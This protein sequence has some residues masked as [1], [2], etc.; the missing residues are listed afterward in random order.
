LNQCLKLRK[1][2]TDAVQLEFL[3]MRIQL[4]QVDEVAPALLA[5]VEN[6]HPETPLILETLA[7]AYMHNLRYG[8][9][10]GCLNLWL[11]EAPETA[12]AY[13]WRGW[14]R[15]RLNHAEGA[16]QDYQ[17]GL[18]LDPD[19]FPAR[20][21]VAEILL[22][23][24]NP[25]EALP[26]LERLLKQY[27]DRPEVLARLG[28]CRFLQGQPEE[29]RRLLEAAVAKLP[30]DPVL[31]IYLAKLDLQEG[32]PARAEEWVRRV[33]RADPTDTEAQ[34]TLI[35]SLR[36]QG[37]HKEAKTAL[38]QYQKD[39]AVLKR[40][41][42]LLQDEAESPT[43]DPAPLVEI[44]TVFIRAGQGRVGEYWLREALQRDPEYKPA[45]KA[46]AE[47]LQ[48]K[49]QR[50]EAAEHRRHLGQADRKAGIP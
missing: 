16:F 50:Q 31:L 36:G 29:A 45:H 2:D 38:D 23:K 17:R 22:E 34:Y 6:H 12:Q 46:L 14:V 39:S 48:S 9:A 5:C 25:P 49:G 41:Y 26:H 7:Q 33:L 21:R 43:S 3:L 42:R 8:P 10:L 13:Y 18:E 27:P 30:N 19:H 1:D 40:A 15:E 47:Y 11:Q 24:S 4:N 20:L 32:R 35:A 28:Q 44:G 37:R